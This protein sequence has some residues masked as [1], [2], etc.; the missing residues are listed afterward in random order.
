VPGRR[1]NIV[2]VAV[3]A[4][5]GLP[6][7]PATAADAPS[8][9]KVVQ[10]ES[11]AP[12]LEHLR[13]QNGSGTPQD[14]HVAHLAP[15]AAARLRVVESGG[16]IA[17][18]H[19]ALERPDALCRRVGCQVAVNGDFI[20]PK[21]S[22]PLGGVVTGGVMLRS[23]LP[24]RPQAWVTTDG[25]LGAGELGFSGRVEDGAGGFGINGVNVARGKD[26]ITVYTPGYGSKTP[27]GS[28]VVELVARAT[29]PAQIG[30]LGATAGLTLVGIGTKGGTKIAKGT[31]V[32]S[33]AGRVKGVVQSL[34]DRR[35]QVG[36]AATLLLSTSP[37][38]SEAIGGNPF[39]LRGGQRAFGNSGS[40]IKDREPRTLVG[41]NGAG[42]IWLV[43]VDGRQP[44][45]KGW[46]M[47]EAADFASRLGATDALNLDG[48][49]GTTF[50][51]RGSV[52]NRPSD[53]KNKKPSVR[54]AVNALTV[55]G[56]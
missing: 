36:S 21:T 27:S 46:S 47:T 32:I 10:R 55:V 6:D 51:V 9:Y 49:G 22:Q 52:V 24:G 42:D 35:A 26:S 56:G 1:L 41:W 23:P 25:A 31:V 5:L 14:V 19:S 13:L 2:L 33:A 30:R 16:R 43:T 20:T 17:Q 15:G 11:L 28:S 7:A 54:R 37:A 38:V 40:F 8:G 29:D 18:S 53:Q 50:V 39:V 3:V 34:W 44:T 48:G 12:G 45:S 4:V